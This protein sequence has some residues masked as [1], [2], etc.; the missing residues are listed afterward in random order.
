MQII[1][2]LL[3]AGVSVSFRNIF[4]KNILTQLHVLKKPSNKNLDDM[5]NFEKFEKFSQEQ[6]IEL[7]NL[8]F[9]KIYK[10]LNNITHP[11]Y[12]VNIDFENMVSIMDTNMIGNILEHLP[13]RPE[14]KD[15]IIDDSFEGFLQREFDNI[16]K[17]EEELINFEEFCIWR[18]N[19]GIV[20]TQDEILFFYNIVV[21]EDELC[22]IMQFIAIN[23]IIDESDAPI[24]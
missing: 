14:T 3:L 16:P 20:L 6:N 5:D 18:Q 12:V 10:Q 15:E 24:Y 9:N 8:Y 13:T 11:V 7:Q 22:D 17:E 23:H 4:N 19:A 21:G 1:L 2:L